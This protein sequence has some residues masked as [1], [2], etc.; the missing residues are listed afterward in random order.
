MMPKKPRRTTSPD[1]DVRIVTLGV[2]AAAE[3][4][5]DIKKPTVVLTL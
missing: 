5:E 1:L 4:E 2:A 3:R